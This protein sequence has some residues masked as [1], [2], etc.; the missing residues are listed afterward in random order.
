MLIM[1]VCSML[2]LSG[3]VLAFMFAVSL[4]LVSLGVVSWINPSPKLTG[5]MY[6]YSSVYMLASM[7]VLSISG[8]VG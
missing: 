5:F 8:L 6:K 2:G 7:L 4:G 3:L 1:L